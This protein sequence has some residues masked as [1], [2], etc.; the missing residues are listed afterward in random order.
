MDGFANIPRRSELFAEDF[1]VA[2]AAPEPEIIEPA[3]SASEL[4]A[5]REAAWRDGQAAGLQEAA[6][7]ETAAIRRAVTVIAEQIAAEREAAAVIA[8]NSAEAI[9]KLL[10]DSL[11]AMFPTLCARYGDAEVRA[12][13]RA[14]LP[15]LMQE[16]AVT[17]RAHPRTAAAVSQEI[18]G[19]D[20][21]LVAHVKL[22]EC[23]AMTPGDVRVVWH[24]GAAVRDAA[25]LWQ[26]V[27]A[28]LVPEGLL[29]ADAMIRETVDAS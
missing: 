3:F 23:D 27:A 25:S 9:A 18:A 14:V 16:P 7:N 8:E 20:P 13:I 2:T 21:D 5:A 11:A 15:P 4:T 12:I 10:L 22:L 1:D 19:L 17:V 6:E 29:R 28:V 24:N 26:Q